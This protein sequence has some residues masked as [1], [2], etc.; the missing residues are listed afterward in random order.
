MKTYNDYVKLIPPKWKKEI[1]NTI[2]EGI[3]I[4]VVLEI[5]NNVIKIKELNK[6]EKV[7]IILSWYYENS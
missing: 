4:Y 7:S 2:Q 1:T 3:A 6:E 5:I